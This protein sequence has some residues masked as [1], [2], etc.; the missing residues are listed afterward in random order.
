[1]LAF[2]ALKSLIQ[3]VAIGLAISMFAPRDY[4]TVRIRG[5]SPWRGGEE[6]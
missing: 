5:K 4:C 1:M 2:L 3:G 6:V